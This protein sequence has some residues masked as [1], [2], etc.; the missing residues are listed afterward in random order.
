MDLPESLPNAVGVDLGVSHFATLSTGEQIDNP[1]HLKSSLRRL[2]IRQRRLSKKQKGSNNRSRATVKVAAIH[3]R[4]AN[5]RR[6]F[7]HQVSRQ[8]VDRFGYIALE[9]LNVSGMVKNHHLAQAI[10]DVGWSQFVS[11][12]KYKQ[13]W[14][15]GVTHHVDHWFASSKL[16]SACGAKNNKLKL[17]DREWVCLDCGTSHDRDENAGINILVE[18]LNTVGATEIYA[19]GDMTAV[20]R[21]AQEAQAL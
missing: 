8:L 16:C 6:D 4:V 11:F 10:Q 19:C 15:G 21:S 9:T 13:C 14:N 2:K 12:V 18:S 7:H 3:E 1:R 17:S 5:Q 20:T